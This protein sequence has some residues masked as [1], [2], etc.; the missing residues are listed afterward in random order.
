MLTQP[1][2]RLT[3]TGRSTTLFMIMPLSAHVR[4]S[5]SGVSTRLTDVSVS[6]ED[7]SVSLVDLSVTLATV[8][9]GLRT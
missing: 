7:M 9:A 3:R 1:P 8:S 5:L 4:A 2:T 6:L